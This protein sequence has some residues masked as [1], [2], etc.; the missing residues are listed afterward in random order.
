MEIIKKIINW[1]GES[2]TSEHT[3]D[4]KVVVLC[5]VAA[6][7]FWFFN[8]LNKND[9]TTVINYPIEFAFENPN[10]SLIT[11]K[12]PPEK[13]AIDVSGRGWILFRKTFWFNYAP[14]KIELSSPVDTKFL[15]RGSLLPIIEPQLSDLK[16]N[17]IVD[18]TIFINIERKVS[19]KLRVFVDSANIGLEENHRITSML[20]FRPDSVLIAGPM[21]VVQN[22]PGDMQLDIDEDDIDSEFNERIEANV[23]GEPLIT[24]YPEKVSVNFKVTEFVKKESTLSI[25]WLEFPKQEKFT[26]N[27]S[28]V[29][30]DYLVARE[31]QDQVGQDQFKATADFSTLN[32]SDS[33]ILIEVI[34][35]SDFVTDVNFSPR[36]IKVNYVR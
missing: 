11:V 34:S 31:N 19:K 35:L 14:I 27:D 4:W 33:T 16:V 26:T 25:E 17:Y 29:N 10:D 5:V 2:L 22:L 24:Y 28:T 18:D 21:S 13:I 8:A 15:T 36:S 1:L 20:R 32:A 7:T 6:T 9:Y 3:K 12:F 23:L 30:V